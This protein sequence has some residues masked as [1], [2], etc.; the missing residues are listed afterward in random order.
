MVPLP[1]NGRNDTDT[2]GCEIQGDIVFQVPDL[3]NAYAFGGN[4][5]I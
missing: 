1:G 3:R 2:Q 4:N 5:L